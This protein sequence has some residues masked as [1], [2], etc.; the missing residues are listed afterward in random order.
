MHIYVLKCEEDKYYVGKTKREVEERLKEHKNG[1]GAIWTSEYRANKIIFIIEVEEKESSS[2]ENEYTL[3]YMYK[4][5]I[6]NV[7]GGNYCQIVLPPNKLEV[8]ISAIQHKYDLCHSCNQ[9]GH[10]MKECENSQWNCLICTTV[11]VE[12]DQPCTE[13][14]HCNI[15][16]PQLH[17]DDINKE[18]IERK[19][20]K[21]EEE[22]L[23][24]K[25]IAMELKQK[26]KNKKTEAEY[27]KLMESITYTNDIF[28]PIKHENIPPR[29][30]EW[31]ETF[32]VHPEEYTNQRVPFLYVV[33]HT[34]TKKTFC[35]RT[36]QL[37]GRTFTHLYFAGKFDVKKIH[38]TLELCRKYNVHLDFIVYDDVAWAEFV[39]NHIVYKQLLGKQE[40]FD[41]QVGNYTKIHVKYGI[42]AILICNV[43]QN[44]FT[45]EKLC[46]KNLDYDWLE[47]NCWYVAV[48]YDMVTLEPRLFKHEIIYW[49][50][51][52]DSLN[53]ISMVTMTIKSGIKRVCNRVIMLV[54][55]ILCKWIE[56][57]QR[58]DNK[59]KHIVL[60]PE[61][62][63]DI[64][65]ME[66]EAR[67][68]ALK[69][70]RIDYDINKKRAQNEFQ[71]IELMD[72]EIGRR[73]KYDLHKQYEEQ[74]WNEQNKQTNTIQLTQITMYVIQFT[75][76]VVNIICDVK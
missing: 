70:R 7:R 1:K 43:K 50:K 74:Q 37:E 10:F 40:E 41:Y 14:K 68:E 72:G 44:V 25:N 35:I 42:P 67:K 61:V 23:L 11:N 60:T 38:E 34:R 3:E 53:M 52:D 39:G 56:W 45:N 51:K 4:Y 54:D 15:N 24:A 55:V 2:K 17:D 66:Q 71:I 63:E 27:N 33:G 62:I 20:R 76:N 9:Q 13:C 5:G 19:I 57:V 69:R 49:W 73:L 64:C 8:V 29:I 12:F 46:F 22:K 21:K 31:F 48:P 32:I 28:P 65:K 47:D 30:I 58:D 26:D 18:A 59:Y 36:F 75:Q 16:K 6:K